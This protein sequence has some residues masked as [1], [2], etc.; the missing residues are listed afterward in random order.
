[1]SGLALGSDLIVPPALL[2]GLIRSLG[3]DGR[4][5][6]AYFGLWSFAAKFTLALAAGVA[7]PLL[8]ILGYRPG[9]PATGSLP[10]L[11]VAYALL[12][13]GLKVLSGWMLWRGWMRPAASDPGFLLDSTRRIP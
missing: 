13:C 7:L 1:M 5:E 8:G 3:H 6:G 11:V 4:L 2:A 9:T 10:P 12:P